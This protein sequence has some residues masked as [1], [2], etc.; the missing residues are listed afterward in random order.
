MTILKDGVT[1]NSS[2]K[3]ALKGGVGNESFISYEYLVSEG[4]RK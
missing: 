2:V 1:Q 3:S 4:V